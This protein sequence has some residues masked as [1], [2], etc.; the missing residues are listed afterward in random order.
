MSTGLLIL[1]LLH[2]AISLAAIAAG[3]VVVKQLLGSAVDRL[4]TRWFLVFAIAT[5]V[6]GYFFPFG[7][8]TPAQIVGAVA[9]AILALVLVAIR[10]RRA[11]AWRWIYAVG[12]VAS[13][14]LLVFVLVVQL[15]K[16][17]PFLT[18]LAPTGSEPPFQIVQLV[19]LLLFIGLGIQSVRKFRPAL[20]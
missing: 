10:N 5:S 12:A 3:A 20:A 6:T 11:G 7:G 14:Y 9:L 16:H 4:W 19:V 1:V 15:F 17:V 18:P 13:L 8:V 2:T